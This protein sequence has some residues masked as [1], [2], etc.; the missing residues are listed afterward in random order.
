MNVTNSKSTQTVAET[1]FPEEG[2]EEATS[3]ILYLDYTDS[4]HVLT[5]P[6]KNK[7]AKFRENELRPCRAWTFNKKL[8]AGP[9]WRVAKDSLKELTD[10]LEKYEISYEI[11]GFNQTI[12]Q[13]GL[14]KSRARRD[15]K[16]AAKR[17]ADRPP[18]APKAPKEK[19]EKK[20]PKTPR[21]PRDPKA[22]KQ[23]KEKITSLIQ[24]SSR[25]MSTQDWR[26]ST[27]VVN[28]IVTHE[29]KE[30]L[31]S[32]LNPDAVEPAGPVGSL[33]SAVSQGFSGRTASFFFHF[34]Y[35]LG[36]DE[37]LKFW[38]ERLEKVDLRDYTNNF[39]PQY[40]DYH[41]KEKLMIFYC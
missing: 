28:L 24:I 16:A 32:I 7:Y 12:R 29:E 1:N 35:L 41:A 39:E 17:A 23:P 25:G 38:P 3:V 13:E 4:S 10:R 31:A 18:K 33:E 2:Q 30:K 40:F 37:G 34:D 22:T 5:G 27:L 15:E 19:K 14:F 21:K 26:F 6:F 8:F 9:G 36:F 20:T 11:T